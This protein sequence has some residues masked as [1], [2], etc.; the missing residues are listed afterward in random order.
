MVVR[1]V[2]SDTTWYPRDMVHVHSERQR[3][4]EQAWEHLTDM[5]DSCGKVAR[6]HDSDAME[7]AFRA[8]LWAE[9]I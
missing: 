5:V 7:N 3:Q 8:L 6:H 9:K 2:D 4:G 1:H